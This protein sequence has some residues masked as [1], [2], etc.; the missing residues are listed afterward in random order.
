[1]PG[2]YTTDTEDIHSL[3][4]NGVIEVIGRLAGSSNATLLVRLEHEGGHGHAVYKPLRGERPLWDFPPGLYKREV[5]A[6]M[7]SEILELNL[8]PTTIVRE[9]PFGEGSLQLFID[10]DPQE[11]Y[12]S[13]FDS[14]PDLHDRL[15]DFAFFDF[16][17]NNT[18]RKSGH[19]L[20]DMEDHL[21]GIDHGVCFSADFK[22]R[23]VIW[24]FADED[25]PSHL[26]E[27][28]APLVESVPLG[29]AAL[30]DDD[31]VEALQQRV[32]YLLEN[33][34]FPIDHS[35]RRHPWPLI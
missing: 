4:A 8:V 3:L 11:H 16:I 22:L 20:L 26:L 34:Q 31:E 15:R 17:A 10:A 23:T 28:A 2:L 5:A 9:G 12:F 18:D 19:I 1:M 6:R 32:R 7:L 13:I 24:D 21:W 35:G 25:I 27:V 14:R 33:P 30:L 29:L